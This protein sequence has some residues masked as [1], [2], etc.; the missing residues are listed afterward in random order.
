MYYVLL[1]WDYKYLILKL[2]KDQKFVFHALI[3]K[4]RIAF[5]FLEW[6]HNVGQT[7][8]QRTN[9]ETVFNNSFS[10]KKQKRAL[11]DWRVTITICATTEKLCKDVWEAMQLE[12]ICCM[13]FF[14]D[15][16]GHF[17]SS[18]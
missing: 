10:N 17:T 2:G 7:L 12:I 4:L 14:I 16:T 3:Y 13:Q 5:T 9:W 15:K 11:M 8:A 6:L 18:S 1:M